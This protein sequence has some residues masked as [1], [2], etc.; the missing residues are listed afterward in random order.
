QSRSYSAGTFDIGQVKPLLEDLDA[1]PNFNCP[2][3]QSSPALGGGTLSIS[4]G[5]IANLEYHG[6]TYEHFCR[7]ISSQAQLLQQ[8]V[9]IEQVADVEGYNRK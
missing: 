8:F 3:G 9:I 7:N 4:F 2:N 6:Q 1:H 5:S